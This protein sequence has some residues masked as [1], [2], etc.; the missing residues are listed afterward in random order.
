[1]KTRLALVP[2]VVSGLMVVSSAVGFSTRNGEREDVSVGA[3]KAPTTP[4]PAMT[5]EVQQILNPLAAPLHSVNPNHSLEDEEARLQELLI[6]QLNRLGFV[7]ERRIAHFQWI[8]K[9]Y[10][11]SIT[12]W[13]V[14]ATDVEATQDGVVITLMVNPRHTSG[15]TR[16]ND[17][18]YE[19]YLLTDEGPRLLS[20]EEDPNP[21]IT[22]F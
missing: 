16:V 1:M 3:S 17:L 11:A 2:I 12:S 6:S 22:V 4:G 13:Q 8:I 7:P 19:T 18:V 15:V 10:G 14:E 9:E 20:F 5:A 21:K